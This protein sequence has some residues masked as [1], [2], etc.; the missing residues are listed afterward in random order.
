MIRQSPT[1]SISCLTSHLMTMLEVV[2]V[3]L[4]TDGQ[5]GQSTDLELSRMRRLTGL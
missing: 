2:E 5:Y 1:S 3:A 4:S